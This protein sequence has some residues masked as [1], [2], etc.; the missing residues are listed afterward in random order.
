ML[1]LFGLSLRA[2][3][4]GVEA[5]GFQVNYSLITVMAEKEDGHSPGSCLLDSLVVWC[6]A[7][8]G[9]GSGD[10]RFVPGNSRDFAGPPH[11]TYA[12]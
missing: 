10:L 8:P 3:S 4:S 9:F 6:W 12:H 7:I 5:P 2:V 11:S 1:V